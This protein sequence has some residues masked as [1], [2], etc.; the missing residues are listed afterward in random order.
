[1]CAQ[2]KKHKN[3]RKLPKTREG[4]RYVLPQSPQP[5]CNFDLKLQASITVNQH[6]SIICATKFVTLYSGL[7]F[8]ISTWSGEGEVLRLRTSKILLTEI[9]KIITIVTF[10]TVI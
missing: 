1:M 4:I 8:G 3:V 2:D 6:I 5:C 9:V 10:K 7:G